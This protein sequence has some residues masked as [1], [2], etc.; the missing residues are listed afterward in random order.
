MR[1]LPPQIVERMKTMTPKQK[2]EVIDYFRRN[3]EEEIRLKNKGGMLTPPLKE[4]RPATSKDIPETIKRPTPSKDIPETI[5]RPATSKDIPETIKNPLLNYVDEVYTDAVKVK[6][7]LGYVLQTE[8]KKRNLEKKDLS[9]L[10]DWANKVGEIESKNIPD[11]TQN[12]KEKGI[13]RGK[14]QFESTAGSGTAVTAR[15]RFN[16]WEKENG[17]LDIPKS[18]RQ[19]LEKKDPDFSKLSEQTQDILFFIHHSKH[20]RTPLTK[21]AK[22]TVSPK[23]AWIKYHWAGKSEDILAK[24]TMWNARFDKGN[25]K[26]KLA[27]LANTFVNAI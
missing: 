7:G 24:E 11:S 18:D 12:N 23:D 9:R 13:G 17:A 4:V 1:E 15:N 6:K 26:A 16:A 27:N 20:P 3:D 21:I 5:K 2:Q 10:A 14:Y 22:G 19:E 25:Y 8:A